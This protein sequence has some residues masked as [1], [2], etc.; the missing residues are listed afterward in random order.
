MEPLEKELLLREL[1]RFGY[2]LIRSEQPV[3]PSK[4]LQQMLE[5][6]EIRLLEGV[7]VVLS[8]M[9]LFEKKPLDL[10]DLEKQLPGS[11]Q[12]RF[13]MLAAVTYLFLFWVPESDVARSQLLAFLKKREPG[14]L[15]LIQQ[16][17]LDRDELIVGNNVRLSFERLERIYK[18][19]VVEQFMASESN[20]SKMVD[21]QRQ[22]AL[23][24]S[25]NELFTDKQRD[26]ILKTL[27]RESLTKTDKEYYSRIVKRRLKALRN[28]DLQSLA[29][30]LLGS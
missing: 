12:K 26:L 6:H 27:N 8:N 25:L 24:E 1:D 22:L 30:S 19:Y 14:L 18:D 10:L 20:L 16:K 11:L 21:N 3:S 9:L 2:H 15:E 13:R 5:A 7:P 29:N 17:S 4:V 23:L 28:P